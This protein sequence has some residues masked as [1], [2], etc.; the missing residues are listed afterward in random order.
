[1]ANLENSMFVLPNRL[2]LRG[3]EMYVCFPTES[4]KPNQG[5]RGMWLHFPLPGST[6]I[7]ALECFEV[8][9]PWGEDVFQRDANPVHYSGPPFQ[10]ACMPCLTE[11]A[12]AIDP[13]LDKWLFAGVNYGLYIHFTDQGNLFDPARPPLLEIIL[14]PAAEGVMTG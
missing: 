13:L 6:T 5:V 9:S 1:M 12:I 11:D 8:E 3:G 4:I 14:Q 7:T 2:A 10:A